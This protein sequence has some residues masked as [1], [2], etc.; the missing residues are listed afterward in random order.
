M[1]VKPATDENASV[2]I[3]IVKIIENSINELRQQQLD[4][5]HGL[6]QS[7]QER[8]IHFHLSCDCENGVIGERVGIKIFRVL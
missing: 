4:I 6:W 5:I 3:T 7:R 1:C 8:L 2:D